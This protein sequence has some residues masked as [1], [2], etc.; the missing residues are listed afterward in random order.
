MRSLRLGTGKFFALAL[1]S[2]IFGSGM[3]SAATMTAYTVWP[4]NNYH[5]KGLLMFAEKVDEYTNGEV[6]INVEL[7]GS[8]GYKGPELMRAV[9]DGSLQIAEMV[10]TGVAGDEP[11]FGV[12]SLPFLIDTWEDAKKFDEMAKEEYD[13]AAEKWGQ[14]ILYVAPWPFAGLW[15]KR[16][17]D[18]VKDMSGLKTRTYDRNGALIMTEVGATPIAMPFSECYT[19]LAT[20]LIDSIITSGTTVR[21]GKLWEVVKYYYPI[22]ISITSSMTNMNL[23]EYE[24]LTQKQKDAVDRASKEVEAYLWSAVAEEE[25]ANLKLCQENGVTIFK[26][27]Q[28]MKKELKGIGQKVGSEWI[29]KNPDTKKLYESFLGRAQ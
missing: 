13:K 25:E 7:A 10:T 9:K 1:A 6:K 17:V 12:R 15:T 4:E 28:G 20:G 2:V 21:D 16:T 27:D 14:K 22:N 11:I 8:L 5:A 24:K 29:D 19:S 18:S 3:A 26:V 23:K